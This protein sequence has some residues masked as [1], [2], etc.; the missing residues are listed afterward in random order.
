M[1]FWGRGGAILTTNKLVSAFGG[2]YACANFGEKRSRNATMRVP[3]DGHTHRLTDAN[4]FYDLSHA[5]CYIYIGQT[6]NSKNI[7]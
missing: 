2:S 7:Q 3:T 5:I 1:G 4:R 6:I